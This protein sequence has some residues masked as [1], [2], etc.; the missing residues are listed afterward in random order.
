MWA[1]D[2]L[3]FW[4]EETAPAAWFEKN[5]TLDAEIRKRFEDLHRR[6]ANDEIQVPMTPRGHLAAVIVLDQFSRNMFRGTTAAFAS[7]A[8]ALQLTLHAIENGYDTEMTKA[9]RQF[10]YMPL[11]HSE[12]KTMQSRCV[13]LFEQLADPYLSGF[14][15]EHRQIIERFGRFPHRN[16]VLGRNSTEEERLFMQQHAGF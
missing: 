2:V 16:A 1:D 12:D 11:M 10:L 5:P 8:R 15:I 13:E 6:L 7:D 14:A 4:F 9:E 3:R